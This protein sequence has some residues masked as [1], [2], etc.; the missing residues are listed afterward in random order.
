MSHF[1]KGF[2]VLI[3]GLCMVIIVNAARSVAGDIDHFQIAKE[4]LN[5]LMALF[6]VGAGF[7]AWF[8]SNPDRSI[9]WKYV[10][11]IG[12]IGTG[13]TFFA[14]DMNLIVLIVFSLQVLFSSIM[15]AKIRVK[16]P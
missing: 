1:K 7:I 15:V 9:L 14:Y 11:V 8:S 10:L 12:L 3:F 16:Y 5:V 2:L 4:G 6:A 13:V